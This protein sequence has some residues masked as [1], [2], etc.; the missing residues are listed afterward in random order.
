MKSTF[1]I[2]RA[3][4][5]VGD[6]RHRRRRTQKGVIGIEMPTDDGENRP[7]RRGDCVQHGNHQLEITGALVRSN[8]MPSAIH[9]GR[10]HKTDVTRQN[11]AGLLQVT[12]ANVSCGASTR[13][14]GKI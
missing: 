2:A 3:L 5:D 1:T 6:N 8:T 4:P 13:A 9:Q 14:G 12:I 11:D 10:K 7:D